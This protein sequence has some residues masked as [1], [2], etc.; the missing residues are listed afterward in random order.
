LARGH[1]R[2]LDEVSLQMSGVVAKSHCRTPTWIRHEVKTITTWTGRGRS[3]RWR[4]IR[5][6]RHAESCE[7]KRKVRT[8]KDLSRRDLDVVSELHRLR[9]DSGHEQRLDRE[10]LEDHAR[11][12]SSG[13]QVARDDLDEHVDRCGRLTRQGEHVSG[14]EAVDGG[15]DERDDERPDR[16]ARGVDLHETKKQ[17]VRR[18]LRRLCPR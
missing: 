17:R 9:K 2:D 15:K 13:E 18:C 10:R 6:S 8:G 5:R 4:M 7:T 12:G 11:N 3:S 1:V 14:G 16:Y